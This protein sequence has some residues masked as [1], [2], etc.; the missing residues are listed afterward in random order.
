[1]VSI[2][3]IKRVF[4]DIAPERQLPM[5][6]ILEFQTRIEQIMKSFVELCE[7]E[8]G[9]DISNT[10]LSEDHVKLAFVN[11]NDKRLVE[12]KEETEFGEWNDEE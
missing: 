5:I 6:A 3:E 1:M 12:R 4:E 11:F 10:R 8:A 2:R 7:K 9:G